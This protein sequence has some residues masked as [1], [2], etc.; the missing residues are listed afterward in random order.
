[1]S[2]RIVIYFVHLFFTKEHPTHIIPWV[3]FL[4]LDFLGTLKSFLPH[5]FSTTFPADVKVLFK[6]SKRRIG[7]VQNSSAYECFVLI[8]T[9]LSLVY[10]HVH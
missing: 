5:N 3:K 7:I 10:T 6:F 8:S 9:V 1:M 2:L 4:T